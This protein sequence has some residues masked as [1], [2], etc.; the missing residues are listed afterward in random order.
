MKTLILAICFSASALMARADVIDPVS[1]YKNTK[2]LTAADVLYK[3]G[4]DVN[5]DGRLEVLLNLKEAFLEDKKDRQVPSWR[6][7]IATA[8]GT[9]SLVTG[10]DEG[11]GVIPSLPQIDPERVF[12]GQVAQLNKRGIV[13]LQSDVARTGVGVSCIYAYTIE[14]DHLKKTLLV[15]YNSEETNVIY[16]QYLKDNLRTQVQLQEVAP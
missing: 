14:G 6:V 4:A 8:N 7:Y 16:D 10:V 12:V 3:W 1:D 11:D 9:F 5:G 15:Q 2:S 13:T